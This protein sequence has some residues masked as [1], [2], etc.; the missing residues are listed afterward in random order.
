M[1]GAFYDR[2]SHKIQQKTACRLVCVIAQFRKIDLSF[3][4]DSKVFNPGQ[5]TNFSK[6]ESYVHTLSI[7]L[8]SYYDH[9]V[10]NF[11]PFCRKFFQQKD[12]L[13]GIIKHVCAQENN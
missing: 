9:C 1:T 11:G 5:A 8:S 10:C 6:N 2:I 4:A 7:M 12:Q 13:I 3:G